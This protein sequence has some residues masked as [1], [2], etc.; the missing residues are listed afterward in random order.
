[1]PVFPAV[2]AQSA[3]IG[4]WIE[5]MN[6]FEALNPQVVVPA[7]GRMGDAGFIRRYR[8]YLTAVRNR[9]AE[10]KRQ[11]ASVEEATAM[12]AEQLAD[13]FTDLQPA[14][15]PATGRINAAIQAAY[16]EIQ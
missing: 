5:N 9:V 8:E 10:A 16:R 11:G 4:K 6:V 12:L 3:S 13:Q 14:S 7:H 15:G 1:M 2:S